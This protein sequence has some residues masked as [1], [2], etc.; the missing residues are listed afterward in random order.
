MKKRIVKKALSIVLATALVITCLPTGASTTASAK[1][2][3]KAKARIESVS[4]TNVS[5]S[6]LVLKKKK[7]YTLK[8][9]V[10]AKGKISKKVTF[11][12]SNKKVVSV[13]S[14]GKL[15]ALKN[16]TAK[17]T[18]KSKANSKKKATITVKVGTPVTSVKANYKTYTG[19]AGKQ[20]TLKATVGP[21]NATYKKVKF[22]TSNSRV[23]KVSSKGEVSLVAKGSAT[24]TVAA[25]DGSKKKATCVVI[26]K[27]VVKP[28]PTPENPVVDRKSVV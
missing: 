22:T 18:V 3:T 12:S 20:F 25:L 13:S 19:Y 14:K 7:T 2:K 26:V 15:K 17:I 5:S 27:E 11:H 4:I 6:T 23:A 24:I 8:V 28:T 9:G 21:K 10:K 1:T 16:G